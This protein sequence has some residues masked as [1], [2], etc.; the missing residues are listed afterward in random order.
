MKLTG[1]Q[2]AALGML[3]ASMRGRT[4]SIMLAHGF[5]MEMLQGLVR[6]GLVTAVRESAYYSRRAV[7]VTMLHITDVGRAALSA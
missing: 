3:A 5:S 4:E 6:E 1:D 7:I 2:R